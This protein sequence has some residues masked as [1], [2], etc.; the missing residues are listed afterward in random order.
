MPQISIQ[1]ISIHYVAGENFNKSRPTLLFVHGAGQRAYTWRFQEDLFKNHPDFN[2]IALDLPGRAGSEG[3]GFRSVSNYKNFVLEFIE[4]LELK[5][6]ILVGHS[7]GGGISM[8]L[9][10]EHPELVEAIILVATSAKL[11]VARE[12][13]D[14]VRDNY[15]EFCEISPNRAFA[16]ESSQEL[17][18]EYKRGLMDAGSEVCYGDLIACNEFDIVSDVDKIHLPTLIISAEKDIMTPAK[19]GEFLHQ[20]IYGSEFYVVKGSGHFV[21]QEKTQDVNNII[22]DFLNNFIE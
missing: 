18:D 10:I 7:M 8:F 3:K 2:Y 19:N 11:N 20:K 9:A 17:K 16:E 13:L 15:E 1:G 14:R 21:M 4:T 5:N 12:T 22:E 6:I